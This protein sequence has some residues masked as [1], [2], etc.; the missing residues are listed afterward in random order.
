VTL[1][2]LTNDQFWLKLIVVIN[3][4]KIVKVVFIGNTYYH[5]KL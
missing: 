2:W 3:E 5:T 4:S 1:F